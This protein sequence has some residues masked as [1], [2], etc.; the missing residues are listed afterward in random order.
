MGGNFEHLSREALEAEL[1]KSIEIIDMFSNT[2][3]G[4][5]AKMS[6]ENMA[7][8]SATEGYYRMTGYTQEESHFPPFSNCGVNLVLPE[9][10][11]GVQKMVEELIR[12]NHPIKVDYRIRRKDGSIAWNT[13]CCPGVEESEQGRLIDV[14]FL[15]STEA[16]NTELQLK[17]LI[18]NMTSGLTR[19]KID[20]GIH[21]LYANNEFYR[22]VG[23]TQEEFAAAPVESDYLRIVQPEDRERVLENAKEFVNSDVKRQS[24]NF[25]IIK[26]NGEIGWIRTYASRLYE[27]LHGENLLQCIMTDI[28]EERKFEKQNLLNEERFR[29]ISEQTRDVVFDWD[30]SSDSIY[31]SPVF[32]KMFGFPAPPAISTKDLLKGDIFYNEDKPVIEK[33]IADMCMALPYVEC[34]ARMKGRDGGYFWTLHRATTIYDEDCKSIHIVGVISDINDLMKDNLDL[35]HR[36]AHDP[37]TGLMNRM[38]AKTLIEQVLR[39]STS[40]GSHAFIQFDIDR[41]KQINDFMGHAAG[42]FAL[43]KIALQMREMFRSEDILVRMGGDE[44]G[45]FLANIASLEGVLKKIKQFLQVVYCD[46]KFEEKIY[47]LSVSMG[48]AIYPQDGQTFQELYEH[49]DFALYQAKRAG[50][51]RHEFFSQ[52]GR[53]SRIRHHK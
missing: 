8:I 44:F 45:A 2:V 25:R 20:A 37:L 15:D 53:L 50:G 47:P 11:P 13:A 39:E 18:N 49:A 26:K 4:G 6:I 48:V 23:Y 17:S 51:N 27:E 40:S 43:Q 28:T 30:I 10:L 7:I 46:F 41:F 35:R 1:R 12:E 31:Y 3:L 22:Q 24:I 9:D 36:A 29:I 5:V 19:V 21:V 14:F 34:R 33:M 38:A 52:L 32:E 42:D 16:K